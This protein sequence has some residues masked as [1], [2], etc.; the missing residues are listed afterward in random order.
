M[1]QNNIENI[2]H[3][4]PQFEYKHTNGK[5]YYVEADVLLF[6]KLSFDKHSA[7]CRDDLEEEFVV[8]NLYVVDENGVECT[9]EM[10]D[11]ITDKVLREQ[12]R[13][14]LENEMEE[15]YDL[16][17]LTIKTFADEGREWYEEQ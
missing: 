14:H 12:L 6:P 11:F 9:E 13:F 2:F 1:T 8:E 4:I 3:Y 17:Q 5:R 7:D 10:N 15:D 16:N